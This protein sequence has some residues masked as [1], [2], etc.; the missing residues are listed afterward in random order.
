VARYTDPAGTA[1]EL[2]S[3]FAAVQHRGFFD[4]LRRFLED[5]ALP[6]ILA[7]ALIAVIGLALLL[8]RRQRRLLSELHEAK[9][10][11]DGDLPPS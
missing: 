8:L 9:A 7:C 2:T 11:Q 10:R 4:R 3:D 6:I 5:H 1:Q